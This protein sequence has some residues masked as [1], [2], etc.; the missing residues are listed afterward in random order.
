MDPI[1]IAD[2]LADEFGMDGITAGVT[3]GFAMELYEKGIIT[4]KDTDGLELKFGN[5]DAMIAML[6]KMAFRE[7]NIGA[8]FADGVKA[9]AEKIGGDAWKYAMHI[10]GLEMP[11]Y[12]VRGLK[13]HGLSMATSYTG[14]DHNRG[15]AFQEVF[16]I[17]VPYEVDRFEYV[18]KGKLTKWNQDVR[19][20]TC[21]CATMCC[22]LLDMAVPD[23]ALENSADLING[24]SGIGFTTEEV[25][26][27]GER[28]NNL[29]KAFNMREG[30]TRADDT[31]PLRVMNE[32]LAGGGSKGQCIPQADLDLMLDEYYE[33][34][35]WTKDG[36]LTRG[37]L[38]ALNLKYVA[39]ELDKMGLL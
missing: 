22:F 39:D 28:I 16:G 2:R 26:T 30:F 18:G 19:C 27:A 21:D 20:V 32:P 14:A 3:V 10:K 29:A 37:K 9:A 5:A 4:D 8:V 6:R 25:Q 31:L 35:G 24:A 12:D 36:K 11:G 7:G 15:Y 38:E 23:I 1:I 13:A 33:A 34:R 17:P